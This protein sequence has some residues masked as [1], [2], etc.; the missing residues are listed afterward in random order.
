MSGPAR[1]T[2]AGEVLL[3]QVHPSQCED[4]HV[5]KEAFNPSARDNLHLSALRE[6]VGAAEAYRR[7]TEVEKY[8]SAGTWG[9][10]VQEVD[11]QVF[12]RHEDREDVSLRAVDDATEALS[13]HASIVFSDLSKKQRVQAARKLRDAA[14]QRG[15]LYKP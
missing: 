11:A 6:A 5:N 12:T 10:S 9:V 8:L 7:W 1:L 15:C 2:D 14:L 4:G 13:D 3:R